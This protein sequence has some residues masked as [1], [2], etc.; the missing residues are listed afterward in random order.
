M[1]KSDY[2]VYFIALICLVMALIPRHQTVIPVRDTFNIK[3]YND[4]I[5]KLDSL[6]SMEREKT[7][8]YKKLVDSLNELPPKIKIK[9]ANEKSKIPTASVVE[10][11]SIIRTNAGLAQR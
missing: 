3:P 9:Y 1:K 7:L 10:L 8:L 4:S 6:I 5:K 11:D 2:L